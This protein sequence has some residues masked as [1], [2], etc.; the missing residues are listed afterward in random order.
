MK[1]ILYRSI[2]LSLCVFVNAQ[3]SKPINLEAYSG[4]S[5]IL[6]TWEIPEEIKVKS[7]QLFRMQN[8]FINHYL[9][10]ETRNSIERFLDEEVEG[11]RPYFYNIKIE[12]LSGE[13]FSS[14]MDAPPFGKAYI[15]NNLFPVLSKDE[16]EIV[17]NKY[18]D[19]EE[20]NDQ[21]LKYILSNII[22]SADSNQLDILQSMIQY[23]DDPSS[24]WMRY[25]G[26]KSLK[27]YENYLSDNN[28]NDIYQ[29][30]ENI[31]NKIGLYFYN[32]FLLTPIE[33]QDHSI[34]FS[35]SIL[36]RILSIREMLINE[37][38]TLDAASPVLPLGTWQN[39]NGS[40]NARFAV[41]HP[42]QVQSIILRD[43]SYE[44]NIE[45]SIYQESQIFDV[46]LLENME[47]YEL[48]V[49]GSIQKILPI[50]INGY[51]YGLSIDDQYFMLNDTILEPPIIVSNPMSQFCLNEI[52]NVPEQNQ[53]FVEIHGTTTTT[54]TT[55]GLFIN[56]LLVWEVEP[57]YDFN[58]I[59]AD[60]V[61][62]I[63]EDFLFAWIDLKVKDDFGLW[64]TIDTRAI[65]SEKGITE[66]RIPDHHGWKQYTIS[67]LGEPNDLV[68]S[69][70]SELIIP[71]IFALYQNYPN[72]FNS[73]TTISFDLLQSA[74]VSL[75]VNDA[76]GRII[77]LFFEGNQ[78]N[79]GLY[80]YNWNGENFSSGLY[81]MTIQAQVEDYLPII[82][83]RKMIYLK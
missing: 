34:L 45:E 39:I 50:P 56:D 77:H 23:R 42:E 83:S 79:K 4:N 74:I 72:P 14:V 73:E 66:G 40:I 1:N 54:T 9:I 2:F 13:I 18:S 78:M 38:K 28:I 22:V 52:V 19:I 30:L 65:F 37:I 80:S 57:Y 46:E 31:L 29:K 71:E 27:I 61:F 25:A 63:N 26:F 49:N 60:S 75:Y 58:L 62:M 6:L 51:G 24:S 67:T 33:W 11:K 53:T 5:S 16:Y 55:I 59:Y 43:D 76:A 36:N 35:N 64:Q 44:I 68:R 7:I 41:I 69:V 81:F 15:D 8:S 70:A 47:K 17:E 20:F 10:Y 3:D 48:I 82:Y 21:V 12:S 32:Q